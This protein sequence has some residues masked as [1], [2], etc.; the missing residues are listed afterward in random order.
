MILRPLRCELDNL[1][2][3]MRG[4][5]R[6]DDAFQSRQQLKRRQ[7]FLIGRGKIGH[8][9]GLVQPGMLRPDAGIIQPR[10]NRMRVLDLAVVVHQKIRAVA[11][12]HAGPAAGDRGRMQLV[13]AVARRFDAENLHRWI[14]EKRMEQPHRVGAAADAGDQRIRQAALRLLHL[15]PGLVADHRL[16]VA[17]HHRIGMRPRHRADAIE[18]VVHVGDPIA[19]RLVHRVLQ[20]ARAGLHRHHLG[21]K[22]FHAEDVGLLP[23][24]VDRAHIDDAVEPEARAQRRGRHAMLAGAGLGDDA[25]LAHAPR[26]QDLAEHIVDF[27]RAGVIELLTLEID[28]RAASANRDARSDARR[29]TAAT[30]GRHSPCETRP[31]RAWNAGSALA[32]A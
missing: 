30:D 24:D 4:F 20:R 27:V 8:A 12:Q 9:A 1:G 15:L 7:R 13:E 14:V 22:H 3:R 17:H 26:Q 28:L 31:S 21:A 25:F 19:Q 2:D 6:R 32:S 11:V 29:N 5:Q 10:R 16:E 18:G 23:R